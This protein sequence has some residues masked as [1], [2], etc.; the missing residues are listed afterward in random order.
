MN[1]YRMIDKGNRV[2]VCLLGGKDSYTLLK[3]LNLIR[4]E[5]NYKFDIF[6]FILDQSQPGWND[7]A[8]RQRMKSH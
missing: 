2:M 3:L 6:E 4:T 1:D 7:S 5:G 8:L